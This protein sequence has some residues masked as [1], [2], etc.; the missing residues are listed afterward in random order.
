M[1][2]DIVMDA[3]TPLWKAHDVSQQLQDKLEML[4]SVERAFVHVDHETVHVP[5]CFRIPLEC[6]IPYTASRN[7]VNYNDVCEFQ[8]CFNV[9]L[10][11]KRVICDNQ[12]NVAISNGMSLST[13]GAFTFR[14]VKYF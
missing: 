12:I 4:P 11:H 14:P 1:E 3:S 7:I 8:Q 10:G 2:I 13:H 6:V 5:V 9:Q